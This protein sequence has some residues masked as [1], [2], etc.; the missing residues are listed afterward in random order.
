M[1]RDFFRKIGYD[2]MEIE[3]LGHG[4]SS[5]IGKGGGGHIEANTLLPPPLGV[6]V[7]ARHP[8]PAVISAL[9]E[10]LLYRTMSKFFPRVLY[11]TC[12]QFESPAAGRKWKK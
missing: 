7:H 12:V 11:R 9:A 8:S 10:S 5:V 6:P 2:S 3:S 1:P 4:H